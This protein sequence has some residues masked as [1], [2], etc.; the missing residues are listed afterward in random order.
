M[1]GQMYVEKLTPTRRLHPYPIV[2]IHGAGQTATNWMG[3]PDG[4]EGWAK[5]FVAQGYEVYM[6]DQPARGR[7]AWQ[8]GID[9]KLSTF[10]AKTEESLF[11]VPEQYNLWPQAKFHTQWPGST[12]GFCEKL[13]VRSIRAA[14][15]HARI[16]SISKASP[17]RSP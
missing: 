7:S 9:G 5:F 11:S 8:Q 16:N 6:V 2:L 13:S 3:T 1:H 14:R 10:D 4:R 17:R 12:S 15:R